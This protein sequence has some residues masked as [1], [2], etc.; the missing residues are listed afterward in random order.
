MSLL[1]SCA[2]LEISLMSAILRLGLAGVSRYT[3]TVFSLRFA[4]TS[5]RFDVSIKDTSTPYLVIPWFK[6]ANVQ[7]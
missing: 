4:L 6:R 2:I 1:N 7:P 5:S 3:A